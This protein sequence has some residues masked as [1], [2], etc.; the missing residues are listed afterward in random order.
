MKYILKENGV[1]RVFYANLSDAIE[2]YGKLIAEKVE[3]WGEENCEINNLINFHTIIKA[4]NQSA[5][6]RIVEDKTYSIL[7][8]ATGFIHVTGSQLRRI[9]EEDDDKLMTKIIHDSFAASGIATLT[10]QGVD[11]VNY[12]L[13]GEYEYEDFE[14]AI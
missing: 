6:I 1:P 5:D 9:I 2:D 8:Q 14:W 3:E 12:I 10:P 13:Q 4:G 7:I 11:D